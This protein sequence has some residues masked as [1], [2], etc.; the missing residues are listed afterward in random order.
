[1]VVGLVVAITAVAV[2]IDGGN[3][4]AYQRITQNGADSAAEGGAI[5]LASRLAGA[6][7][8]AGGWD[9]AISA[10]VT[11]N[12]SANGIGTTTAYYT[13]ICG[14]PLQA[15]GS[16]ALNADGTEN[17]ALAVQVGSGSL[18]AVVNTTPDCPSRSVGPP[19]GVTVLA[20][21]DLTTYVAP[22]VGINTLH[23]TARATAAAG[24]LQGFCGAEDGAAC[25]VVPLTIPVDLVSCNKSNKA[26]DTGAVWN[27]YQLYIIPLC[28][29]GPGNVGW[30]DWTPPGGGS[31]EIINEILHPN[32][33]PINLPSWVYV[34][35]T[36]GPGDS[37]IQNALRTYDGQTVLVPQFDLT[38]SGKSGDPVNTQPTVSTAPYYGCTPSDVGGNGNSQWYRMPSFAYFQ[39]CSSSQ[40]DCVAQ[41]TPHGAYTGGGPDGKL[42]CAAAN[43]AT[44]CLA[45][46]FV[47]ILASGTVG[48]GV[49]GGGSN[50]KTLGIQLIK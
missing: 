29:N 1:M 31:G 12:A 43:G 30:I 48:P 8:P 47:S 35:Q 16:A 32:N 2:V 36:G 46:R 22:I 11:S 23:V 20:Q 10:Q 28:S 21:R 15:D 50:N 17:L 3:A 19:A 9:A 24:Y 34:S 5:V 18:P 44:Q 4:W 38:C 45:G 13:D 25:S 26:V 6:V 27:L 39:L 14:I 40:P 7:T 41:G 37:G 42:A 33:P 49:G